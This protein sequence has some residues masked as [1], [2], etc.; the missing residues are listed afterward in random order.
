MWSQMGCELPEGEGSSKHPLKALRT[1]SLS[2]LSC[3]R[4]PH[5][6][7]QAGCGGKGVKLTETQ[8]SACAEASFGQR[9]PFLHPGIPVLVERLEHIG[10]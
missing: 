7:E 3:L 4:P 8:R 2:E 9:Y 5:A 1:A 6:G 10:K